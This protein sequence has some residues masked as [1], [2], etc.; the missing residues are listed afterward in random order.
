VK[1]PITDGKIVLT[2]PED[3]DG[4]VINVEFK[5]DELASGSSIMLTIAEKPPAYEMAIPFFIAVAVVG[6]T[7]VMY[8][9]NYFGFATKLTALKNRLFR[10]DVDELV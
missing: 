1:K 9:G 5:G 8:K 3:A 4:G 7:A 6:F 10:R 2:I